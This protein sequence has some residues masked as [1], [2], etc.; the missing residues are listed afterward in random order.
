MKK[1]LI[2]LLLLSFVYIS[3]AQIRMHLLPIVKN[4][5][6]NTLINTYKNF[7]S[8]PVWEVTFEEETPVWSFGSDVGTKTW[9]VSDTTP[10]YGWSYSG[11]ESSP[12]WVYMGDRYVHDYSE[13]GGNFAWIDEISDDLG[14][15]PMQ[16]NETYIQFDNIDL[17][18]CLHPKLQMYQNYRSYGETHSFLDYS[19]DGG[20]VWTSIEMNSDLVSNATAEDVLVV[21][22]PSEVGGNSNVSLRLRWST[23]IATGSNCGY[24]WEV[25]DVQIVE[26]DQ[27]DL[28][29]VDSRMNFFEYADYSISGNENYYHYSSHYGKIP[30]RQYDSPDAI[31]YFNI[32]VTNNGYSEITPVVNVKVYDPSMTEIFSNSGL[33][34]QLVYS[35]TDTI[36]LIDIEF[37]LGSDP[38]IG[39]YT[40]VYQVSVDGQDDANP[41]NNTDTTY[42]EITDNV[43][44]RNLNEPDGEVGPCMYVDGGMDG[45]KI[46]SMFN[47]TYEEEI[48]SVEV[49]IGE[50]TTPG[51]AILVHFMEFNQDAYEWVSSVASALITL[52]ES[53]IGGWLDVTFT[54]PAIVNIPEGDDMTK[55]LIAIEMYY[56]G[57]ENDIFIGYDSSLNASM[58]GTWWSFWPEEEWTC[59]LNWDFG[60]LGIKLNMGDLGSFCSEGMSVCVNDEPFVI[61]G[62]T[63]SGAIF[64]GEHVVENVFYPSSAGV[65]DHI[66]YCNYY[67]YEFSFTITAN[68]LPEQVAL[69]V[70]PVGGI[71]ASSEFGSIDIVESGNMTTY[72]TTKDEIVITEEMQG[73]GS[74]LILGEDFTDGTYVIWSR[75][76]NA[77]EVSQGVVTF[78]DDDNEIKI[79][80]NV[81]YG[82]NQLLNENE[83]LVS[84]YKSQINDLD[85]VEII[86][87]STLYLNSSGVVVFDGIEA[88]E[89][90]LGSELVNAENYNS[91][92]H[93]YYEEEQMFEDASPIVL[94]EGGIMLVNICHPVNP[95]MEGS[96]NG[97]GTVG[98]QEEGKAV[99]PAEGKVVIL[100]NADNSEVLSVCVTDEN[101]YYEFE[102]IPDNM[103]IQLFVSNFETPNWFAYNS[104]ISHNEDF[105]V[106]F[107]VHQDSVYPEGYLQI[108]DLTILDKQLKLFPNPVLETINFVDLPTNF[109]L[110]IFNI[111]GQEV[112]S[113]NIL[114]ESR[115]DVSELESGLYFVIVSS[116]NGEVLINKFVKE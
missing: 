75:S 63:Q 48:N 20:S 69:D 8:I 9:E 101:G 94:E 104:M 38:D 24:G 2:L 116:E 23:T 67:G 31:S 46:G 88:G 40:V 30:V 76:G 47:F 33:G 18:D 96:N 50:S 10:S 43:Y 81:T 80:A 57:E 27:Y 37:A 21:M 99:D 66:V 112:V 41:L 93:V 108:V 106:N 26:C 35:E 105:E 70:S 44:A 65:G 68:P 85:E 83:S 87:D 95:D 98:N 77:C 109:N 52:E 13:S 110:K 1:A 89:Y 61:T 36:D 115:L 71:L 28:D 62:P 107:I 4:A 25:D 11:V 51:T 53:D 92:S 82:I 54:D 91:F 90:Y 14:L 49:F 3:F 5:K 22:L 78:V 111:Q 103:N 7:K 86:L 72:W 113:T 60:G 6:S 19:I 15:F 55:V 39:L 16:I 97:S 79:V 74:T 58:W 84:L 42:F 114:V 59:L 17:T 29:L 73:N 12:L 100:K 45:E 64:S 34:N 102:G 32:A 56:Q